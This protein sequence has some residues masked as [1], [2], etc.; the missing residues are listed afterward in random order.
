MQ[1]IVSSDNM[2]NGFID[3]NNKD[4]KFNKDLFNN[5]NKYNNINNIK[6]DKNDKLFNLF[7]EIRIINDFYIDM[8]NN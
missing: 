8:K 5:K 3:N 2:D 1:S 6:D 4:K 7:K